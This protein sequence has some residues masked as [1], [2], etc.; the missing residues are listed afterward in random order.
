MKLT[1]LGSPLPRPFTHNL[2]AATATSSQHCT[3]YIRDAHM[4]VY[5]MK[6][7]IISIQYTQRYHLYDSGEKIIMNEFI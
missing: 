2:P 6:H 1:F 5:T 4:Y 7:F 3:V